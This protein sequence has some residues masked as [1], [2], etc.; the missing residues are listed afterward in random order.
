[1]DAGIAVADVDKEV[2]RLSSQVTSGSAHTVPGSHSHAAGDGSTMDVFL[3]G[4]LL[5]SNTGTELRDYIE[6]GS[7][8]V[9]FT[10]AVPTNS[11]LTYIIRS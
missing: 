1:M 7:D 2:E 11:Y 3:N 10:F 6:S 8:E 4:Q 5:Q 9:K